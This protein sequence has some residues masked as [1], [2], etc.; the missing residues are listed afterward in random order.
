MC[1]RRGC[2]LGAGGRNYPPLGSTAAVGVYD[3]VAPQRLAGWSC[4][5]EQAGQAFYVERSQITTKSARRTKKTLSRVSFK[6]VR[7]P[8]NPVRTARVR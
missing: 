5:E 3:A 8:G 6:P 1:F 7:R 4:N 2:T